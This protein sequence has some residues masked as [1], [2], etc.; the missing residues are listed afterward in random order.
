MRF[1][2][3]IKLAKK[4]LKQPWLYTES[5]LAYLKR[6]KKLAQ[7]EAQKEKLAAEFPLLFGKDAKARS[8]V[9]KYANKTFPTTP[10]KKKAL[11]IVSN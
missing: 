2:D 6:A 1:K 10:N 11:E 5:E 9:G 4:A 8:T 7:K 3:T